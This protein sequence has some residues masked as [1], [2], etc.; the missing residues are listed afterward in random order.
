MCLLIFLQLYKLIYSL[1]ANTNITCLNQE[2]CKSRQLNRNLMQIIKY[3]SVS[4]VSE[5]NH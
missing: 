3:N 2:S 5:N 4:S 1:I